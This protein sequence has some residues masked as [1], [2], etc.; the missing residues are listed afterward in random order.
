MF[1]TNHAMHAAS[2]GVDY[3]FGCT[4]VCTLPVA[5]QALY[6]ST[7][8]LCMRRNFHTRVI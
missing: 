3:L 2:A 1:N 7:L 4:H 8:Q 5:S 6:L